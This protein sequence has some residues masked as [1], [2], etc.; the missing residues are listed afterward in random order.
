MTDHIGEHQP[1][2]IL[3]D[4]TEVTVRHG[5]V[6]KEGTIAVQ[7]FDNRGDGASA[8]LTVEEAEALRDALAA[9]IG[10]RDGSDV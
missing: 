7:V 10:S 5:V 8:Y 2:L 4:G 9:L 3:D 1:L 6:F